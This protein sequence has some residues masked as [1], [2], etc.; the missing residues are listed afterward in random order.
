MY[1]RCWQCLSHKKGKQQICSIR[2]F[3]Y[4]D[5]SPRCP[6]V[7]PKCG[8]LLRGLTWGPSMGTSKATLR[9]TSRG[10]LRGTSRRTPRKRH[11]Q[12]NS[13]ETLSWTLKRDFTKEFK[14][15]EE[16]CRGL[17]PKI[18]LCMDWITKS[19]QEFLAVFHCGIFYGQ[20]QMFANIHNILHIM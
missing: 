2:Y 10:P 4:S 13:Q 16:S 9:A 15:E 12:G 5:R 17:I 8:M 20:T 18:V 1:W 7:E 14:W 3:F 6:G 11:F 19:F